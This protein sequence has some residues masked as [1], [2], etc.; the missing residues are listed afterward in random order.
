MDLLRISWDATIGY[1]ESLAHKSADFKPDMIVGLSRGG[2]VLSR[3]MSDILAVE[4]VGIIGMSFYKGMRR[5]EKPVIFQE[6][7]MDVRGKRIL[8]VDDVADSGRSLTAAKEYLR[9]KGAGEIRIATIHY[10]PGS[11]FRPDYYMMTTT[12]WVAYPWERHEIE[13]EL[14]KSD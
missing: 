12:S 14:R 5:L 1:C 9:A 4:T 10:K 11:S 7:S 3:I 6:L 8:L 2:L 13:R